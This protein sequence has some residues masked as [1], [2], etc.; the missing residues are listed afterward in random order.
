MTTKNN[1]ISSTKT[2]LLSI[3]LVS[4]SLLACAPVV[5][6]KGYVFNDKNLAQISKGSTNKEMVRT[7]MGGPSAV[8]SVDAKIFYYISSR[9]ETY[10]YRAPK[11]VDRRIVAIH[12]D[13]SD[14]VNDIKAYGL[15][16]GNIVD[17][18]KRETVTRGKKLTF[19]D[20][21]FG[22]IGRFSSSPDGG[23]VPGSQ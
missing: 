7:I 2:N 5:D 8:A 14:V 9:F 11:E 19:L 6:N 17:F 22:N 4:A 12:F 3:Y 21:L 10:T 13:E 1:R 15:Q 20:Q 23:G 16:D 18:M